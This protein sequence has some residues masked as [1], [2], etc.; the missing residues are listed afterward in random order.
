MAMFSEPAKP[1]PVG[2]PTSDGIG[3]VDHVLIVFVAI[4]SRLSSS[5]PL[6]RSVL[7]RSICTRARAQATLEA[8]RAQSVKGTEDGCVWV[9][10]TPRGGVPA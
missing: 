5:L 1:S 8:P 9:A 2:M 6:R 10:R 4:A 7:R 3:L